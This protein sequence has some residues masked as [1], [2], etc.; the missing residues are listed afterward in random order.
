[1]NSLPIQN[2]GKSKLGKPAQK[3]NFNEGGRDRSVL[4]VCVPS[5]DPLLWCVHL[6]GAEQVV[7]RTQTEVVVAQRERDSRDTER[8]STAQVTAA[9]DRPTDTKAKEIDRLCATI[10]LSY[11]IPVPFLLLLSRGEHSTDGGAE[12]TDTTPRAPTLKIGGGASGARE[13]ESE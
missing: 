9:T 4:L 13:G 7:H 6:K 3:G 12:R 8:T 1:M 2:A 11:R 10:P 5:V